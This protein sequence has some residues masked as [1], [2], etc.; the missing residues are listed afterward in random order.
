MIRF[1]DIV[2]SLFSLIILAPFLVFVCLWM[3]V[4]Q[5]FPILFSQGRSGKDFK[6]FR[7]YKLRTMKKDSEDKLGV[8]Q[9]ASDKRITKL[10]LFLRKYKIDEIPQLI[11]VLLGEMSIVGP[12]P[13]VPFYTEKFQTFYEVMLRVR[14]GLLSPSAIKYFNEDEILSQTKDPI[15]YYENTLVPIKCKMDMEFVENLNTTSYLKTILTYFKN[16]F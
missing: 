1:F 15:A 4:S 7:I 2:I 5:G 10:G 3:I 16:I 6:V 9:G 14:P 8:T 13:Q 11:N 12:R